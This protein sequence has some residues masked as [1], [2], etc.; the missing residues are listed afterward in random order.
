MLRLVFE[1]TTSDELQRLR[2]VWIILKALALKS[3]ANAP[4]LNLKNQDE[5]MGRHLQ[6]A[7]VQKLSW[8]SL[9]FG[10]RRLPKLFGFKTRSLQTFKLLTLF[11]ML[12]LI[13]PSNMHR[14]LWLAAFAPGPGVAAFELHLQGLIVAPL[15][16]YH[17]S[18]CDSCY[19]L[20]CCYD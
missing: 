12:T 2:R 13:K 17:D 1:V 3:M 10:P 18:Y 7:G 19:F 6:A 9:G 14:G 4:Q 20:C 11:L 16:W 15:V 8:M 5:A